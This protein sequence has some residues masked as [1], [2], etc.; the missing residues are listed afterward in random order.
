MAKEIINILKKNFDLNEEETNL[1]S[2]NVRRLTRQDRKYFFKNMKP[3]EKIYK[4]FLKNYYQSLDPEQKSNFVEITVSSLLEKGGEP[5]LSDSIAMG[6][7]GRIPVYNRMRERAEHEGLRLN[8]SINFGGMGTVI[9]LVG[10][11][12]AIILYLLAK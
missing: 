5:D 9:M 8:L 11:I 1:M 12:T 4:E 10:G 6:V 2:K 7:A 3:K